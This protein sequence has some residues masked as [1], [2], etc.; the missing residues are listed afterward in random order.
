MTGDT[1]ER[2]N[3]A[4]QESAESLNAL[5]LPPPASFTSTGS[6]W[7]RKRGQGAGS[8]GRLNSS[9]SSSAASAAGVPA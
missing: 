3:T 1:R 7:S 2:A 9:R 8:G 4:L 5:R 6:S